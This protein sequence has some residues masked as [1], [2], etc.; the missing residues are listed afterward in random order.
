MIVDEINV[1][2]KIEEELKKLNYNFKY[3]G[4][5]YL[6]YTIYILYKMNSNGDCDLKSEVYPIVAQKYNTSINNL[7]C[8][9]RNATD[10]MYYDCEQDVVTRYVESFLKPTPKMVIKAVLRRLRH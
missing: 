3:R 10:K 8:D 5:K 6:K 9:I 2:T 4:T 1:E 7:K